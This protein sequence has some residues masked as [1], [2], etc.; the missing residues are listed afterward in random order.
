VGLILDSSVVIAA[1][2]RGD[3]VASL[4][5]RV[6]D[7]AGDQEAALSAVGLTKLVR[8]IYRADTTERGARREMFI[9]PTFKLRCPRSL[10]LR[11][12]NIRESW[13]S[14]SMNQRVT[15]AA[16]TY[17]EAVDGATERQERAIEVG[18]PEEYDRRNRA[19]ILP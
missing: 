11:I 2:R 16:R 17:Y 14:K 7:S 1:E 12:R 10:S 9:E 6:V 13:I 18:V 15:E 8:G 5:Q 4:I 3:T 19:P